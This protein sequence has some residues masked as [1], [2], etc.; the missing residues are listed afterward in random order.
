MYVEET[1]REKGISAQHEAMIINYP[2]FDDMDEVDVMVGVVSG[3]GDNGAK[4]RASK[5]GGWTWALGCRGPTSI[6]QVGLAQLVVPSSP[7]PP[8]P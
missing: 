7:E 5:S 6:V 8:P 4:C 1:E 3:Q 2:Y